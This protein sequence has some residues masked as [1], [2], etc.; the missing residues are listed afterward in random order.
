MEE[1]MKKYLKY[2]GVGF[3]TL[4]V[5]LFIFA[6]IGGGNKELDPQSQIKAT[7]VYDVLRSWNPDSDPNAIGMEI[8]INPDDVSKENIVNLV[9][10]IADNKSKAVIKIYQDKKAWQGEQKGVYGDIFDA[11]YLVFYVKNTTGSGAYRGFNEI[12]W[13]QELGNLEELFGTNMQL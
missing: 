11:G 2:V 12:R 5:F 8:L 6:A 9:Q 3:G 13:M 4:L 1:N 10:K 7:V